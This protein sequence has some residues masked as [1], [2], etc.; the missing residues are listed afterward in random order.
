MSR[1]K[2]LA[3]ALFVI[4]VIALFPFGDQT[5]I[6]YVER[7]SGQV[8]TEQIYGEGWLR[9]LY[10]NPLG[11]LS[12]SAFVKRKF[13]SEWYGRRMDSPESAKKIPQFVK[14]YGID[15][16]EAQKQKFISFN[17]FFSRKLKATARSIDTNKNVLISPA[18]GKI[19]AYPNISQQDF[20]VKGYRFNLFEFFN[21]TTL[22]RHYENGSLII[23]RL[24][25]TDYHRFHFPS[26]GKV[27]KTQKIEGPLY[28][29]SPIALRKKV[30]L[31]CRNKREY[32]Q[33]QSPLFGHYIMAEVGATMVGSIIQT[34]PKQQVLKG[35]EK[36]YFLFGGSTVVLFFEKG[37]LKIDADIVEN[38]KKHLETEVKMGEHIAITDE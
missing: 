27:L 29:V 3:I 15:L 17:D 12:L 1:K 23:V 10:N 26:D 24:C 32:T 36:G 11:E 2:Q 7:S 37:Q 33:I 30:E 5:P 8:K 31:I 38:T 21:D 9:W 35:D 14:Q 19:L 34:Y 6:Q 13:V 18:D 28:S 25:P 20:I 4:L 16:S 22:A